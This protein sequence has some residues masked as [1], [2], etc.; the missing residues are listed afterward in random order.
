M[1]SD[2]FIYVVSV[3][4]YLHCLHLLSSIEPILS[5]AGAASGVPAIAA[6]APGDAVNGATVPTT[7]M[8]SAS[9]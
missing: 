6:G 2:K 5:C 7:S 4:V 8:M 3:S 1:V 9:G